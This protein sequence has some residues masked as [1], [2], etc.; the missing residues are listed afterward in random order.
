MLQGVLA[1][2]AVFGDD[3][4]T[5]YFGSFSRKF[6]QNKYQVKQHQPSRIEVS[7]SL[8]AAL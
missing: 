2:V 4:I 7:S 3:L 6:G 8:C 5:F 1:Q